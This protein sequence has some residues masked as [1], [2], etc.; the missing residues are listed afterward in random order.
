MLLSPYCTK[1]RRS[2]LG[3]RIRIQ[4][5]DIITGQLAA[6]VLVISAIE[7]V[8]GMIVSPITVG[9]ELKIKVTVATAV[10]TEVAMEQEVMAERK[11]AVVVVV[12]EVTETIILKMPRQ[13]WSLLFSIVPKGLALVKPHHN[14]LSNHIPTRP[15]VMQ[16]IHNWQQSHLH[17][18]QYFY[19]LHHQFC[20]VE[21]SSLEQCC[22]PICVSLQLHQLWV[23][24]G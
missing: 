13:R 23:L 6:V 18:P 14:L 24:P 20:L 11:V 1:Q 21:Q 10:R 15:A 3:I 2:V 9:E 22:L 12:V 16:Q 8:T 5:V 7:M 4:V 17:H 19:P